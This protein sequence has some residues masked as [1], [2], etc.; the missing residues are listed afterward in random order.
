[1]GEG[2]GYGI[3][4]GGSGYDPPYH[5]MES[6]ES[7]PTS[8]VWRILGRKLPDNEVVFFTQV[9]L[10]FLVIVACVINLSLN[11]GD[12]NLWTC[13]MS[14]CLGYLLPNPSLNS[15]RNIPNNGAD[16]PDSPEQQ[17]NAI[18]SEQH[19]SELHNQTAQGNSAGDGGMGGGP[20]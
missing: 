14:S 13:L 20:E 16:V 4:Q 19:P 1:M 7:H 11:V 9:A 10:L 8:R 18:L 5:S 17:L 3:I 15:H 2:E 6:T 12:S